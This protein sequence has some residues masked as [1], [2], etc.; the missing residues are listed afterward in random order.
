MVKTASIQQQ[1]LAYRWDYSAR[2]TTIAWKQQREP[3]TNCA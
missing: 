1:A 2:Y 3:T